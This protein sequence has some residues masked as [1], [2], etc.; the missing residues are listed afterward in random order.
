[1]LIFGCTC[2]LSCTGMQCVFRFYINFVY[3]K[4]Y[5]TVLCLDFSPYNHP[6]MCVLCVCMSVYLHVPV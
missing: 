5:D 4:K 3:L 6:V 1:M 2:K